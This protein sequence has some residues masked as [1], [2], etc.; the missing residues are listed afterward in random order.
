MS[1]YIYKN[2]QQSGPYTEGQV[3]EWLTGG[4]LSPDDLAIREGERDWKPLRVLFP[5]A[6]PSPMM[7]G[8]RLVS[9]SAS[10]SGS[11]LAPPP[12]KSGS[13]IVLF[14]LL[15]VGGL[16]LLGAF[17]IAGIFMP[18][19][20][21]RNVPLDNLSNSNLSSNSVNSNSTNT[22][23]NTRIPD[24]S[25]LNSKA[26]DF[27]KLKP[28][29]KTEKS[30]VLKGKVVIVQQ[31]RR[32]EE[33]SYSML[34]SSEA[35][36]YGISTEKMAV[37]PTEVTTI[38]QIICGKGKE[39]GQYGPITAYVPAY[40]NLCTVSIIDYTESKT[41]AQKT[42]V[43]AKRPKKIYVRDD[44]YEYLLDPPTADIQKYVSGLAKD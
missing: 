21:N 12:Q 9:P 37:S 44:E 6:A 10:W 39:I 32:D 11:N 15:G 16:F 40:S 35:S 14:A 31:R 30:P 22:N 43:N 3:R 2:N 20:P 27:V 23:T 17:V 5:N 7:S 36:S 33:Y 4:Y 41:I 18:N 13:K 38:V 25:G 26:Q 8:Q 42:F 28:P 29:L 1:I 19:R 24:S 34:T